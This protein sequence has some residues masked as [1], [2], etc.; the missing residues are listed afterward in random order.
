[1]EF[2]TISPRDFTEA[3][4]RFKSETNS[5]SDQ[6]KM[7]L[8]PQNPTPGFEPK[9]R[10]M[11]RYTENKPAGQPAYYTAWCGQFCAGTL[12]QAEDG[13]YYFNPNPAFGSSGF[14]ASW[15]LLDLGR[16]L[17]ALNEAWNQKIEKELS[18]PDVPAP[19]TD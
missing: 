1:M 10:L 12:D 15:I 11:L 2:K 16:K 6:I 14:I 3:I 9:E 8:K 7:K 17:E 19:F 5:V 18:A 4:R 13:F